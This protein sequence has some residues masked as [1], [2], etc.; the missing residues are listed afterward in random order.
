MLDQPP[1][2][3]VQ[4]VIVVDGDDAGVFR[5]GV[6]HLDDDAALGTQQASGGLL[7]R[8]EHRVGGERGGEM[9]SDVEDRVELGGQ[10]QRNPLASGLRVLG[11]VDRGVGFDRRVEVGGSR[12]IGGGE[13]VVRA[14]PPHHAAHAPP[15]SQRL[16]VLPRR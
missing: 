14:G 8:G 13:V 11:R 3:R 4:F 10:R 5:V 2:G 16:G 9:P 15:G 1:S 6:G 7:H 12:V